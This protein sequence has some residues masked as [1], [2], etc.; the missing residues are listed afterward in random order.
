MSKYECASPAEPPLDDECASCDRPIRVRTLAWQGMKS[1]EGLACAANL[2]ADE[3]CELTAKLYPDE[4]AARL[5]LRRM[6]PA[7]R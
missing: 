6:R 5:R 4:I 1:S 3:E 2:C 7:K